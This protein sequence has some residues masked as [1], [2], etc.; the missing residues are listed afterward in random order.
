V[1]QGPRE[2]PIHRAAIFAVVIPRGLAPTGP[3]DTSRQ[4]AR[5]QSPEARWTLI[6]VTGA[7]I[8]IGVY[9][10]ASGVIEIIS[11]RIVAGRVELLSSCFVERWR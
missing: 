10:E 6:A 11:M 2:E 1:G 3:T 4:I 9:R 8:R 7:A 5:L